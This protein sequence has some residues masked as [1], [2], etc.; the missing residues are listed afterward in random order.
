[1]VVHRV[2]QWLKALLAPRRSRS[3]AA[4]DERVP[5]LV[6][7]AATSRSAPA[8]SAAEAPRVLNWLAASRRL[9]P[10]RTISISAV[11]SAGGKG[12]A[13]GEAGREQVAAACP[14]PQPA[15]ELPKRAE[16]VEKAQAQPPAPPAPKSQPLRREP[17]LSKPRVGPQ[18]P[19]PAAP[20]AREEY[21]QRR[22]LMA[23]K[24]LVRMGVYN[25]GFQRQQAPEQYRQSMGLGDDQ[26]DNLGE[27]E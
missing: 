24:H 25:E 12:G 2:A 17:P 3:R 18:P 27:I 7:A 10:P 19:A 22:R 9:R 15:E 16:A 6:G 20:S 4:D 23:L 13:K 1:M 14:R 5:L 11:Q 8:V 26:A 21:A